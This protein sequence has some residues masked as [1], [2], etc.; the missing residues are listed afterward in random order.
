M[1][2]VCPICLGRR[3]T[4]DMGLKREALQEQGQQRAQRHQPSCGCL[5]CGGGAFWSGAGEEIARFARRA[6]IPVTTSSAARG[7]VPDS[8]PVCLGGLVH[9]GGAL[10]LLSIYLKSGGGRGL[11]VE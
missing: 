7:V 1:G 9:A 10:F 5:L 11:A 4:V 2:A 3:Q 6:N 8:D